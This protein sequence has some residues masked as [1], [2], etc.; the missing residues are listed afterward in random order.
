MLFMII[1]HFRKNDMVPIYKAGGA[2]A[3]RKPQLC[4]Q[5]GRARFQPLL[6]IDG[7]RRPAPVA[8]MDLEEARVGSYFRNS[9]GR[10][11]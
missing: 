2:H 4:G 5:V 9:I 8:A 11:Q 7:M 1:E 10:E 3:A 6:S